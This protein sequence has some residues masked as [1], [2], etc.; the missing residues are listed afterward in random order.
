MSAT[1][2]YHLPFM[3][4]SLTPPVE[5]CRFSIFSWNDV[6]PI[7]LKFE[8][9]CQTTHHDSVHITAKTK[10]P[11]LWKLLHPFSGSSRVLLQAPFNQYFYYW[12]I[13]TT[14]LIWNCILSTSLSTSQYCFFFKPM[15]CWIQSCKNPHFYCL[16]QCNLIQAWNFYKFTLRLQLLVQR[17]CTQVAKRYW[18][19]YAFNSLYLCQGKSCVSFL[20]GRFR[21][22]S[23]VPRWPI[24][25]AIT[26]RNSRSN[27][28]FWWCA[29]FQ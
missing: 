28:E 23:L 22:S 5:I 7:Q 13:Q 25:L 3:T 29:D 10:H 14:A 19:G 1:T 12:V 20:P 9:F 16:C 4:I 8:I 21:F 11:K 24:R 15:L 2:P 18:P 17:T 6:A 26:S 27:A